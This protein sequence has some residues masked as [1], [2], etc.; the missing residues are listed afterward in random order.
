M[1]HQEP[2]A[3]ID[4]SRSE[5]PTQKILKN[6]FDFVELFTIAACAI[7]LVF[8]LFARLTVVEGG[9]MENT[10]QEGQRLVISEFMYT[11]KNGDIVVIQSPEVLGGKA[12]VK[13]V[14]AT[15]GQTVEI[16]RDGVY[17]YDADGSGGKLEES[18][19]SLGYKVYTVPGYHYQTQTFHVGKGEVFVM[20]DHRDVS[21][22]SR[23]FGCVD[24][25]CIL[26][27]AYLR[28][29]PF[30]EFGFLN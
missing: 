19:G 22:D 3:Q 24:E 21:E 11:P 23:K 5:N 1:N 27:K 20:G 16:R 8:T 17:V 14:I 13:R 7:L 6:I 9:S 26:G 15:E 10:L 18:N 28:I 25:R 29:S 4:N 2:K 12:I 30:S